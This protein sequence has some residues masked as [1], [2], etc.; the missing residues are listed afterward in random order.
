M[1]GLTGHAL[2]NPG[3]YPE[4]WIELVQGRGQGKAPGVILMDSGFGNHCV[5]SHALCLGGKVGY[6]FLASEGLSQPGM[7]VNM[8]MAHRSL[9]GQP[10]DRM[11]STLGFQLYQSLFLV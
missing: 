3:P 6:S 8:A 7:E 10:H 9:S 1:L 11:G 2:R 5:R 4:I